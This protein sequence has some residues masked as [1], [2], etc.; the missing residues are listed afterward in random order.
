VKRV[1][2]IGGG[3]AGCASAHVFELQGGWDVTLVE[4]APFLGAGVKTNFWG[5]HPYTFGPRHFL[6]QNEDVFEFLNKYVPLRRC[7]DHQF[8]TY[9]ERDNKFYNYPIHRD[10]V[11]LMPDSDLV[12]KE[13]DQVTGVENAKNLEEYWIGSVGKTLYEKMILNYNKKMWMVGDNTEIDT[14]NWSPKGVALKEGSR[15]AWDTAISAYP[16]APDGYNSYFELSTKDAT[17]LL[18]TTIERY[19][20]PNKTVVIDGEAR[21]YD[22]IVSTISPDI[23]F[24]NAY[25]ELAYIGRDFHKIVLPVEHCFPEH[26][27]FLYYANDEQFTRLVEY[28]KFTHHKSPTTMIGMEIPSMNGK[29]YPLPFRAELMKADRYFEDMPEG[30]FSIGRNGSYR[31]G[32]D[33]DDC[34]EQALEVGKIVKQGGWAHAVP[35]EKHRRIG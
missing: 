3:F 25:G 30:V 35:L 22:V 10:D 9:V 24:D 23:L 12:Q 17:V 4:K 18:S 15:E 33:I 19:D 8:I 28:K 11:A 1:L 20:I 27:Y 29:Y 34:I 13:L 31:Y 26:V 5:G 16:Y 21:H 7:A 32:V 14:F 2:I 6:T